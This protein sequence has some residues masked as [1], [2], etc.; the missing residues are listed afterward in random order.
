VAEQPACRSCQDVLYAYVDAELDGED[1]AAIFP[2]VRPHLDQCRG[3]AQEY[4]GLKVLLLMERQRAFDQPPVEPTFDFSFLETPPRRR[5]IW[6]AV[7]S[8][9]RQVA[10]LFTDVRVHVGREWAS[11]DP[12]PRPLMPKLVAVP[13]VREEVT[14]AKRQ[15]QALPLPSPEHDL[16][17]SLTVGPVS[18]DEAALGVQVTRISSGRPLSRARVTVRDEQRRVLISELTHE[19]GRVT[20]PRIGSGSY[21]VEVKHQGRLWELPV[22]FELEEE[23][24]RDV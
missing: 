9:G 20:F 12:L 5:S 7:E 21:L 10:R 14:E 16:S 15:A 4:G 2:A 13:V 8:A 3:C 24:A 19:D 23:S 11:F 17:L 18:G 22:T 1:A 6:E